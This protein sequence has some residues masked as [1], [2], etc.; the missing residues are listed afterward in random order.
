MTKGVVIIVR[1]F[2]GLARR[3][4][5]VVNAPSFIE[6]GNALGA[7]L[8]AI[9]GLHPFATETTYCLNVN[10]QG[11][12]TLDQDRLREFGCRITG[13]WLHVHSM[14]PLGEASLGEGYLSR[15]AQS[16]GP[17]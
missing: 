5:L 6:G 13:V 3:P 1:D 7:R 11:D 17:A 2:I 10:D 15:P 16:L 14:E 4:Y 12:L 9:Q 8:A